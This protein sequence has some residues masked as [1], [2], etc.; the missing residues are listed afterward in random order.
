V[1]AI[2]A[3]AWSS[4]PDG[5]MEFVNRGWHDYTGL[6]SEYSFGV[7]W[8][9]AIHPEDLNELLE[10]WGR[11]L[12]LD[13][14]CEVRLRGYNGSF[15]WFLLRREPLLDESGAVARWYVTG[16]DIEDNRQKELLR[17]AEKRTLRMIG[18]GASLFQILNELCA[19]V[20]EHTS[21]ISLV[22]LKDMACNQ[23]L[24]AA[25]RSSPP[26]SGVRRLHTMADRTE[27][28]LLRYCGVYEGTSRHFRYRDR[29]ALA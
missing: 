24:P 13:K 25:G 28:G 20:D 1:D 3:L 21:A 2:R 15:R 22:F 29:S 16:I 12:D 18:D 4:R 17:T 9:A 5:A 11:F 8:R 26:A 27:H 6:S 14:P 10:K 19:A 23:F 7:G